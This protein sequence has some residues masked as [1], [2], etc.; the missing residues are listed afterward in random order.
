MYFFSK[1]AFNV[2]VT[3]NSKGCH[4]IYELL[5]IHSPQRYPIEFICLIGGLISLWTGFS[6]HSIY[7]YGKRFFRR[8]Q[9]KVEELDK[10][11][12]IVNYHNHIHNPV[13]IPQKKE[14]DKRLSI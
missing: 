3:L 14:T 13:C 1:S 9:N 12:V 6:L 10:N 7:A 4:N 11:N 5:Y 2:K 8:D